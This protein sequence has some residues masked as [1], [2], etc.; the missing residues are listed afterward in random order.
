MPV[1]S[2]ADETRVG[3]RERRI[4]QNEKVD[5]VRPARVVEGTKSRKPL[6]GVNDETVGRFGYSSYRPRRY[7]QGRS[8]P[9]SYADALSQDPGPGI[10]V[11]EPQD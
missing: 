3:F 8:Y 10:T 5:K 2:R 4:A 9:I 1:S 11:W 7:F 6:P